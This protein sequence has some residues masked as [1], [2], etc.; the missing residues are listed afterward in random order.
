MSV[1]VIIPHVPLRKAYLKRALHSVIDQTRPA[2]AISVI[3]DNDHLG[4][5]VIRNRGLFQS[6]TEYSLFLDDD[7]E[8]QPTAIQRLLETAKETNADLVYPW[9]HISGK[10]GRDPRTG[11][12]LY[13]S[14]PFPEMFGREFHPS[15]IEHR[16]FIPVTTL[17][18][19]KLAIEV[20][21]FPLANSEDWPFHTNEDWGFLKRLVKADAKFVHLPERLWRW[22]IHHTDPGLPHYTGKVW[23]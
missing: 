17:V 5:A 22:N 9:F 15:E 11:K 12:M 14:D 6:E 23:S 19:T 18:R 13:A 8:L 7:D 2:D 10:L 3:V 20:G 4:P 16:N 1:T 21:G